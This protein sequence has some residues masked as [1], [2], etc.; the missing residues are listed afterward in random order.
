MALD[1]SVIAALT[2]ELRSQL[3][4]GR[5]DRIYQPETDEIVLTVRNN[6]QNHKVLLSASSNH[7]KIHFTKLDKKNPMNPPN[8]CMVLR[9]H[10]LGGRIIDIVQPQFE[11][12]VELVIETLDE[13]NVS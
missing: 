12:M 11:R 4:T 9:K 6:G 3:Y 1:G 13:L 8:F 7:P 2:Y 10:L 5:I